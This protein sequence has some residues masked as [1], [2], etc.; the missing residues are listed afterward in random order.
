MIWNTE[1]DGPPPWKDK[2]LS[3]ATRKAWKIA[4]EWESAV[5]ALQDSPS[6][7]LKLEAVEK[8]DPVVID[9]NDP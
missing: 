2:T 8:T 3:A 4:W 6:I 5:A 9:P 7:D 1:R